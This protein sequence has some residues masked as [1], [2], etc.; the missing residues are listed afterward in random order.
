MTLDLFGLKIK[1]RQKDLEFN[2]PKSF[3]SVPDLNEQEFMDTTDLGLNWIL[4]VQYENPNYFCLYDSLDKNLNVIIASGPRLDI[5]EKER[6]RT[7]FTVP[8]LPI[9]FLFPDEADGVKAS[10]NFPR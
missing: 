10:P 5:S 6:R 8:A 4:N 3:I 1:E 9:D 2:F 7:F